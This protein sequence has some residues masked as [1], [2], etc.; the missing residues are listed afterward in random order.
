M[1]CEEKG[2]WASKALASIV[3][4][5]PEILDKVIE[6]VEYLTKG[7]KSLSGKA[8]LRR[9]WS[10]MMG[11]VEE[12]LD[13][14]KRG[15]SETISCTKGCN[16]CCHAKVDIS[17][18]EASFYSY[19]IKKGRWYNKEELKFQTEANMEEEDYINDPR[20]CIFLKDGL[21]SIYEHRP[22]ACRKYFVV[23]KPEDCRLRP[24]APPVLSPPL[25]RS[26]IL[27]SAYSKVMGED[28]GS[29]PLMIDR[30]LK[31]EFRNK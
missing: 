17:K 22:A 18:E 4:K 15:Y 7:L 19:L 11:C 5:N 9:Y 14:F 27:Y 25:I 1:E 16:H 20:P 24:N 6:D 28:F 2:V 31:G 3:D 12:D 30:A 23:S 21:C 8:R 13:D 29:M 10:M 26:E